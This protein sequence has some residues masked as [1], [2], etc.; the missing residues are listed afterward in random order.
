VFAA[1]FVPD[2]YF[3]SGRAFA[4]GMVV[5]FGDH[6]SERD[7]QRQIVAKMESEAVPI[8]IF[9]EGSRNGFR[10]AFPL[11]DDYLRTRFEE[12]GSSA[13]GDPDGTLYAVL[14]RR[15]RVATGRDPVFSMPCFADPA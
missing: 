11:V 9:V 2:L 6:W 3:F 13:F 12:A 1:W 7:R 15:D 10:D 4:G 5:V 14:T 8:A